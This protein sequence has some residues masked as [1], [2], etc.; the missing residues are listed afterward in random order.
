MRAAALR[1]AA[2]RRGVVKR[3]GAA[4]P[5]G[6][7]GCTGR[8]E[9]APGS[10]ATIWE[11]RGRLQD[12]RRRKGVT[13]IDRGAERRSATAHAGVAGNCERCGAALVKVREHRRWCSGRCRA[14]AS[15]EAQAAKIRRMQILIGELHRLTA[16][17][18]D[19]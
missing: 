4:R 19:A 16:G 17:A 1:W 10:L 7:A 15:R 18:P 8:A 11:A 12:A 6:R 13:M 5:F 14:A 2:R 3:Q 9:S